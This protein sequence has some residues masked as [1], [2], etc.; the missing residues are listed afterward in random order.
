MSD[1]AKTELNALDQLY[2]EGKYSE[3]LDKITSL[4]E[5]ENLD[6]D[7]S[8]V[9]QILKS[10]VLLKLG[11]LYESLVL[12]E[13]YLLL[14]EWKNLPLQA[15]DA[16]LLR[17]E[18]YWHLGRLDDGL[19][20]IARGEHEIFAMPVDKLLKM[21]KQMATLL[22][23]KG[24]IYWKKGESN[25]ALKY[26]QQSLAIRDDIGDKQGSSA[27]VNN[28]GNIYADKGDLD[29]ALQYYEKC[30]VIDEETGNKHDIAISLQNI[31][32]I[33]R[34]KGELDLALQY[35]EKS[36]DINEKIGNEQSIALSLSNI[37]E[38]H[39]L[40]GNLDVSLECHKRS[41]VV[42]QRIGN[43]QDIAVSLLS[44]GQIYSEKGDLL[45]V[46]D[47]LEQSLFLTEDIGNDLTRSEILYQMI[48]TCIERNDLDQAKNYLIKLHRINSKEENRVINQRYRVARAI[49]LKESPKKAYR[50]EAKEI[51]KNVVN[52]EIIN[53]EL[54]ITSI[55]TLCDLLLFDLKTKRIDNLI[56][57]VKVLI[58]RFLEIA[59]QQSSFP[60]LVESYILKSRLA[61]AESNL[62][63]ARIMLVQAQILVEEKELQR[64]AKKISKEYEL[65]IE[66][67]NNWEEICDLS[68][69]S[70]E[71]E[72]IEWLEQVLLNK[73]QEKTKEQELPSEEPLM[74]QVQSKEGLILFSKTLDKT[75]QVDGQVIGGFLTAANAFSNEIFSRDLNIMKIDEYTLLVK[76]E[77]SVQFV[78]VSKGKT[79]HALRTV[80]RLI[81][82]LRSVAPTW[83]GMMGKYKTWKP[84]IVNATVLTTI[85]RLIKE[86]F[87]PIE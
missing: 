46:R 83:E 61:L 51:L 86:I 17:A 76:K 3:V 11:R 79:E 52:A 62:Y 44:L 6:L 9:C 66:K 4:E 70:T 64:L 75:F 37:G 73:E 28:I 27:T 33:Y 59:T 72:D 71:K 31:G 14:I 30:L 74:I 19:E 84:L 49:I 40:K 50:I 60:L 54:T 47:N 29:L 22:H 56:N 43:K 39:R 80:D 48:S 45:Q 69:D 36:Y 13:R 23:Y 87:L 25:N 26:F 55:L 32:F 67:S 5:R 58:K 21:P 8:L 34:G 2:W 53:H 10:K 68:I 82:V 77:E 20:A 16:H 78:Y 18:I 63:E 1:T 85:E 38:I 57:E 81:R 42:K 24:A 7:A 65:I 15:L 12:A 41:L 35:Y